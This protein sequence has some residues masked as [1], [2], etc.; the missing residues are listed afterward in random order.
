MWQAQQNSAYVMHRHL[1]W[2]P[3]QHFCQS[4]SRSYNPEGDRAQLITVKH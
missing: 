3:V 1:H 2:V 4:G